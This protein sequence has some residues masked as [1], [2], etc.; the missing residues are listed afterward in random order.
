MSILAIIPARGGSKGVPRKNIRLLHGKPLIQYTIEAALQSNSLDVVMVSTDDEE[1]ANTSRILGA[2]VPELRPAYLASDKSPTI[3]TV[4]YTLKYYEEQGVEF[5]T[6]MLLQPTA[7]SRTSDDIKQA[8]KKYK[9]QKLD[10]LIS[11]LPTPHEYSPYW[12]F[13]ATKDGS[14]E[15]SVPQAN[16]ISRR[17]DLPTTYFR[18]GDIY[19]TSAEVLKSKHSL[20]GSKLG[21]HV[22]SWDD[23]IN[24]D[25]MQDWHQAE[26]YFNNQ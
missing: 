26:K 13:E 23:H 14:L 25:T 15:L 19:I 7:P 9:E 2:M 12:S 4:L 3:D 20:Y 6:V 11:V 24:I 16:L 5:D 22:M 8:I 21:Y 17:Q 18:S 10:S 1:I